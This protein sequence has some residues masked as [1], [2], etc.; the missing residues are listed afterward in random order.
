MTAVRVHLSGRKTRGF[1][2]IELLVVIAII[3]I[4]AALL[5]PVL[6]ASKE[7][8]RATMCMS[9]LRQLGLAI[10]AYAQDYASH[11]PFAEDNPAIPATPP[12]ASIVDL[13]KPYLGESTSVF[14]CPDDRGNWFAKGG[15]SYEYNTQVG[16]RFIDKP[17]GGFLNL[18]PD[19]VR[20]MNDFENV[21]FGATTNGAMM[22][23]LYCDG[24]VQPM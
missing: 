2:L 14:H 5:T 23:V 18:P 24:H 3:G 12:L 8:A 19:Q 10:T 7:K 13:L 15:T 21:H 20:I 1:T 9:N 11:L 6:G 4:L 22:N 16:G 17:S